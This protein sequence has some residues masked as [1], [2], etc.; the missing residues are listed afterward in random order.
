MA[1]PVNEANDCPFCAILKGA[2]PGKIIARDDQQRFALIQSIHPEATIHW[3][4]IPYEHVAST[5]V[6]QNDDSARFLAL[7]DFAVTQAKVAVAD[8]PQLLRGFS[9]KVHFGSFETVS[10]AKLHVLS[11]E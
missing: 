6:M 7:V 2:E 3:M 8:Y 1:N 10:H 9:L 11:K 4:A 5:E